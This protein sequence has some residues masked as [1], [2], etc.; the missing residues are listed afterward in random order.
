MAYGHR[1][2]T[3]EVNTHGTPVGPVSPHLCLL[4]SKEATSELALLEFKKPENV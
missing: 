3:S 1:V 4:A 2:A